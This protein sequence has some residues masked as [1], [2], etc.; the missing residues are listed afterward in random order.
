MHKRM[1]L[2]QITQM[3]RFLSEYLSISSSWTNYNYNYNHQESE[4][5]TSLCIIMG[6]CQCWKKVVRLWQVLVHI[7]QHAFLIH[8]LWQSQNIVLV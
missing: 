1:G 6:K 8:T 5:I 2:T 3:Q 4:L 7:F